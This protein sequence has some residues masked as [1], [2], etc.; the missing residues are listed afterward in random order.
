MTITQYLYLY[1]LT[2]PLVALFDLVWLGFLAKDFY[3]TKLA[4]LL[5]PVNWPGAIVFYCMYAGGILLFAVSPA[6]TGGVLLKASIL[7][8]LL[9][10][11]AYATYDLT[12][13]AT[14]KDWPLSVVIVDILWGVFLTGSV[15]ALSFL[16]G[17][18][19]LT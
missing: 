3:Q 10:L 15:S 1:L 19:I 13:Y 9:G 4:Y 14:I 6:L 8:A 5:G 17:K 16:I 18:H 11:F 7:G 12:N 2:V